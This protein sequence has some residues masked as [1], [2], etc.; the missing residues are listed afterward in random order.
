MPEVIT[1]GIHCDCRN[2]DR[3]LWTLGGGLRG[4]GTLYIEERADEGASK[5]AI[6]C[7]AGASEIG[8]LLRLEGAVWNEEVVEAVSVCLRVGRSAMGL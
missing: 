5:T 4:A 8:E 6:V 1:G 7:R 3:V 2:D